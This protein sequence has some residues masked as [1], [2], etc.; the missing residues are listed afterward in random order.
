MEALKRKLEKLNIKSYFS[1]PKKL[2]SLLTS[3]IKPQPKSI[4]YQIECECGS[5]YNGETKVGLRNRSKQHN[6]IIEK[7]DNRAL[8][9]KW[10]SI[11]SKIVGNACLIQNYHS[12]QI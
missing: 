7:G 6:R 2:N 12:S 1:Y 9:Q 3:T 4:V 5:I 10:S 8:A 11:T